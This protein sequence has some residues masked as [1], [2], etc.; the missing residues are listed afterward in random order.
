MRAQPVR[1]AGDRRPRHDHRIGA[2]GDQPLRCV[3]DGRIL[4]ALAQIG[5]RVG[6]LDRFEAGHSLRQ[7]GAL[8][9]IQVHPSG[10]F[11]R[12]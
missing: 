8:D 11:A 7:S 1:D 6:Q 9:E 4:P 5:R 10:C 3:D 2:G 12:S